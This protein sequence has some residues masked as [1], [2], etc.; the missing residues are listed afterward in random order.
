MAL[1]D[2]DKTHLETTIRAAEAK[3]RGEIRCICAQSVGDYRIVALAWAAI[4]ALTAVP[5]L[6]LAPI[7][8][9]AIAALGGW[10]AAHIDPRAALI[11]FIIVQ[12]L[13]FLTV[14]LGLWFTRTLR[15]A[16]TPRWLKRERVHRTALEQFLARGL[17]LTDARTGVLIFLAREE[18]HAEILADEG[19]H[20]LVGETAWAEIVSRMLDKLRAGDEVGALTLAI[21]ETGALLARHVPPS[22]NNPDEL[23]NALIEM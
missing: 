15:F 11:G 8:F 19:I 12:T 13:T 4:A 9:A 16:V 17:H 7:D 10:R 21:T 3:T 5:L 20:A 1:S 14:A 23:P 22:A 18:R 6:L 2:A